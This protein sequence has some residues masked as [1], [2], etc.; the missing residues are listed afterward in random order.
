MSIKSHFN[1]ARCAHLGMA[2]TVTIGAATHLKSNIGKS[3]REKRKTINGALAI[4][5]SLHH[6]EGKQTRVDFDS[7][8]VTQKGP[9]ININI[10]GIQEP[11]VYRL[12]EV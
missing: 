7:Y 11:Y 8:R 12:E 6:A 5:R 1:A 3:A 9:T 4:C 2:A 10:A